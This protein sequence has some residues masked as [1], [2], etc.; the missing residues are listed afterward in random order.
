MDHLYRVAQYISLAD[1]QANLAGLQTANE[2]DR[3]RVVTLGSN[4]TA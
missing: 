4:F 1:K 2:T 3:I